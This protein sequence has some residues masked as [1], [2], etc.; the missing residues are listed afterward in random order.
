MGLN[1]EDNLQP[2]R[3]DA[4]VRWHPRAECHAP[5]VCMVHR[6]SSTHLSRPTLCHPPVF[7]ISYPCAALPYLFAATFFFFAPAPAPARARVPPFVG[8]PFRP[9]QPHRAARVP[10]RTLHGRFRLDGTARGRSTRRAAAMARRATLAARLA[11]GLAALLAAV[12]SARAVACA[13]RAGRDAGQKGAQRGA[14][15][16]AAGTSA[17]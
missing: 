4:T 17:R 5:Q 7:S 11:L 15:H 1:G 14:E 8:A 6:G 10:H 9:T 2:Q 12:P 13:L 3:G 16:A